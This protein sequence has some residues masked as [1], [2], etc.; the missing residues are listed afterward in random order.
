MDK[1]TKKRVKII[2]AI[3]I[4][5]VFI[6][7]YIIYLNT[8]EK[9][10]PEANYNAGNKESSSSIQQG[11]NGSVHKPSNVTDVTYH[12]KIEKANKKQEFFDT[13]RC[14][15]IYLSALSR[16]NKD[17]YKGIDENA[18]NNKVVNNKQQIFSMLDAEYINKYN[19]T[20]D[21]MDGKLSQFYN[22]LEFLTEKM[23]VLDNKDKHESI[24]F[25]YGSLV[26]VTKNTIQPYGFI[27]R[28]F[29]GGTLLFTIIPY[30]YM[31][32]NNYNEEKIESASVDSILQNKIED[33]KYNHYTSTS[34]DNKYVSNYY[35]YKYKKYISF[36][37]QEVYNKLNEDYKK[38]KFP[39]LQDYR[40]YL[41]NNI[42]NILSYNL[43]VSNV[44]IEDNYKDYI[45][46]D[47]KGNKYIFRETGVNE[48]T[49]ILN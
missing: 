38:E 23:Y 29:Y 36:N 40:N 2:L 30:D 45:C 35:F 19:L 33:K 27:I 42:D 16:T 28:R 46:A 21:N 5:L 39:T 10:E 43:A 12:L 44:K 17:I 41:A 4:V 11:N 20:I 15:Q 8:R 49:I 37:V 25:V 1:K 26:N 48:Y 47:E 6:V 14:I 22:T 34:Y 24:Y 18:V 32:E 3:V 13:E 31:I 9:E 7:A